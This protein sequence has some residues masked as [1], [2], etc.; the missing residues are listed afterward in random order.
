MEFTESPPCPFCGDEDPRFEVTEVYL[1]TREFEAESC[2]EG[3]Y[4]SYSD[5]LAELPRREFVDWF[6]RNTGARVRSLAH[7]DTLNLQLDFGLSVVPVSQRTAREFIATHHKHLPKAPAG[8]KYGFAVANGYDLV[9]VVWV[10]RPVSRFTAAKGTT[11]EVSRL[12][13]DRSLAHAVRWNAASKL[14]SLAA[15]EAKRRGYSLI[16]TFTLADHETGHSLKA[17]GWE[18]VSRTQGG[19]WSRKGRASASRPGVTEG[20]KVK[21]R[22]ILRR[23]RI[24]R[25]APEELS[26]RRM[27]NESQSPVRLV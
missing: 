8:W 15:K 11:L 14:Y 10:G 1:S 3:M 4:R 12:A 27:S 20:S 19:S 18:E 6:E 9:G 17:S 5:E 22:R 16:E 7:E 25:P 2:C 23:S 24:N 13:I 21:W 26:K